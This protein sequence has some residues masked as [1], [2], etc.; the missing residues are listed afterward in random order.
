MFAIFGSGLWTTSLS[1]FTYSFYSQP[2][3]RTGAWVLRSDFDD[4]DVVSSL[5]K[6]LV[7]AFGDV[8][9]SRK[10]NGD[11]HFAQCYYRH[12]RPSSFK[13]RLC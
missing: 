13:A 1:S 5:D 7:D 9:F 11:L 12:Y 2:K 4:F 8:V 6:A 3:A 10:T